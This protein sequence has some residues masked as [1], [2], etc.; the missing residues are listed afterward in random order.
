M[1]GEMMTGPVSDYGAMGLVLAAGAI[2]GLV[3]A[4][5]AHR[6]RLHAER[7]ASARV[8][9]RATGLMGLAE[10]HCGVLRIVE[11]DRDGHREVEFGSR[12]SMIGSND[13]GMA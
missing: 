12:E 2:T 13:E 3:R 11:R 8:A 4:F 9:A 6:T 1:V 10:R 7:E 5:I